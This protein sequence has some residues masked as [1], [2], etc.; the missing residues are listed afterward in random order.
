MRREACLCGRPKPC[1]RHPQK[2]RGR[3]VP[4]SYGRQYRSNRAVLMAKWNAEPGTRCAECFGLR[5]VSDP[6]EPDHIV[7]VAQ[8]GT[9][10]L[11]NLRP[12][13][14]SC[15]RKAGAELATQRKKQAADRRAHERDLATVTY[16]EEAR[17]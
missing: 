17:R 2:D 5:R 16:L 7:P 13:H 1:A 3:K 11:S 9:D 15:N 8:G 12:L 10:H 4:G 14:R 6:W